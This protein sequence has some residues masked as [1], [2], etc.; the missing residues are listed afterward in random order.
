MILCGGVAIGPQIKALK[1]RRAPVVVGTPGRILDHLQRGT[2]GLGSVRYLVLDEADRMLD[3]GFAPDVGRILSRTPG[4]RQTAL[5]SATMPKT[6]RSMVN[7]HM[8]SPQWLAVESRTPTVDTVAQ[9]SYR[10][11]GRDKTRALRSLI[12]AEKEP[13]AIVFRR[14]KHGATK[15]HRQLERDGY[16]AGLLHGGKTQAQRTKTLAAFVGGRTSILIATNVAARGLDIPDVSH[17]INYDLP[18]DVE[19]YVHRIGRT[20]RAGREGI[21]ATLVGEAEK[22]EFDKIKRALSVEVRESSLPL[23]A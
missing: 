19:T 3:M 15:L 10:V 14:T 23:S 5:F 13:R 22:R 2:L 11:N 8:R 7:S 6:I 16:K 1:G 12:D 17:V 4:G 18:E 9:V 21:A 20:A